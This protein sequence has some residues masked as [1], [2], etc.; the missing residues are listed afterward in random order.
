MNNF[1]QIF[2]SGPSAGAYMSSRLRLDKDGP[3][4]AGH[5]HVMV[6]PSHNFYLYDPANLALYTGIVSFQ[7]KV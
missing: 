4:G 3:G 6:G 5:V 7:P 2:A 1:F